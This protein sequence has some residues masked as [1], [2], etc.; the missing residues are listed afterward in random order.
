VI[1]VFQGG[2]AGANGSAKRSA[3]ESGVQRGVPPRTPRDPTR[4][5]SLRRVNPDG[6]DYA[7]LARGGIAWM[8]AGWGGWLPRWI[9]G[10]SGG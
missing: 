1:S 6:G 9:G 5:P 4:G 7:E 10:G 8:S 3:L 2:V